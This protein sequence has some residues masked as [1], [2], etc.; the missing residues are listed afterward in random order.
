MVGHRTLIFSCFVLAVLVGCPL[1]NSVGASSAMW[2]QTYGGA[3]DEIAYSLIETSDGGYAIAGFTGAITAGP[4]YFW[5]VKTDSD[6]NMQ[7]NQTYKNTWLDT[8]F[9]LVE[10]SD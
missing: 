10:T 5:L 1:I 6:G 2:S 3:D 9:S 8:A 4:R 7:W